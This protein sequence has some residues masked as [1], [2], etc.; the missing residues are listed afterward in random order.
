[1]VVPRRQFLVANRPVDRDPIPGVGLEIEVAEAVALTPPCQGTTTDL[2]A[3][4]PVEPLHL[5]VGTL[6]L[7][8]PKSEILFIERIVALEYRVGF[9]H[10]VRSAAAVHVFPRRFYRVDV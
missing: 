4:I 10:G 5:G 1:M 3:S 7:V 2:I 9:L 8:D 6:L